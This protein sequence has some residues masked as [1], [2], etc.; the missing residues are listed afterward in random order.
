MIF[1]RYLIKLFFRKLI[2]VQ[3]F[4]LV[5]YTSFLVLQHTEYIGEYGSSVLE[6]LIF[7]LMKTPYS[8]YQ[9]M[10]V[11]VIAA[12]IF[13]VLAMVKNHEILAYVSLGGRIRNIAA[14]FFG[15]GLVVGIFLFFIGEYV[16]PKIEYA[17]DK[18]EKEAIEGKEYNPLGELYDLW[19]KESDNR[20]INV[21]VVDPVDKVLVNVVEYF[22]NSEGK[23]VKIVDFDRGIYNGSEWILKDYKVYDTRNIPK[24]VDN[25]S[26]KAVKSEAYNNIVSII[27]SNPKLL[28]LDELNR[29]IGLYRS[30]GLNAD[31]Y[32][33][34]FYNKFAHPL[35]IIVLIL[36]IVPLTISFSRQ[37]SYIT[38]AARAMFAGF[39]FWL[40]VA[41]CESMG[42]AGIITPF[43]AN[44]IPHIIFSVLIVFMFYKKEYGNN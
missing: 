18:Y 19:V 23:I 22:Y 39:G 31:K 16:N 33:L 13:T 34:L 41:S 21:S 25:V 35:S 12:T 11:A 36:L 9:T 5:I 37:H 24:M 8:L 38:L 27:N 7:D 29:L 10:P 17:R 43:L 42:R 30:K 3:L 20:F 2:F 44:F 15:A 6:I 32:K 28:T 26:S 1:N 40:A 4:I 14:V